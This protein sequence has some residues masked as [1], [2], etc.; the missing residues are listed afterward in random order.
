MEPAFIFFHGPGLEHIDMELPASRHDRGLEEGMVLSAHLQIPGDDRHQQLGGG[1]PPRHR[2][3]G[4]PFFTWG[5]EP[6]AGDGT[7]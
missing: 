3:G 5:S 4:D 1:D 6:I 2:G 7:R